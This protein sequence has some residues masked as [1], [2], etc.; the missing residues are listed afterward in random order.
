MRRLLSEIAGTLAVVA[1]WALAGQLRDPTS[2]LRLRLAELD[3]AARE[4]WMQLQA[5]RLVVEAEDLLSDREG[6]SE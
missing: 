5:L 1:C 2:S 3:E 4:W 6:V